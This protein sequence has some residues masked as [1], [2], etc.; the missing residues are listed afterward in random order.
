MNKKADDFFKEA[1]KSLEG[2]VGEIKNKDYLITTISI[3]L[4]VAYNDGI[5]E[6][7]DRAG[8]IFRSKSNE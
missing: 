7:M 5:I 2:I 8:E 1:E 6:G 3:H 4:A